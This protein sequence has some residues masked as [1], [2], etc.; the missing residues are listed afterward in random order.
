M[1]ADMEISKD[2]MKDFKKAFADGNVKNVQVNA[3]ILT[4]GIWPEQNIIPIRLP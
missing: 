3:D 1:F 2:T 4:Q